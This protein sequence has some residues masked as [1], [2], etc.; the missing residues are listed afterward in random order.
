[1][2]FKE[3]TFG[4]SLKGVNAR[5]PR[6]KKTMGFDA[7]GK[8]GTKLAHGGGIRSYATRV[9]PS[10][11][12]ALTLPRSQTRSLLSQLPVAMRVPSGLQATL[13]TEPSWSSNVCN[14]LPVAASQ[15]LAVRSTLPVTRRLP[16]GLQATLKTNRSCPLKVSIS[17]ALTG[18][19]IFAV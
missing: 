5:S 12:A 16:S 18:S 14:N 4:Q 8:E 10:A 19:Q 3:A 17:L 1:M 6:K 2:V 11:T 15:T 13:N 9:P 7:M